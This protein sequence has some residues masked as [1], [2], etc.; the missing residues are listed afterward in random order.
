MSPLREV[1][2]IAWPTVL[3]MSSYTVMQFVDKLM[4]AQVGPLEVA[5]Q[6]NGG[7][8]SFVP[9]AFAMG[10]M[11]V[12]NTYVS[13]NL[14][15]GTP[16][17]GPKYAWAAMWISIAI[18]VLILL[19]F[20]AIM[21]WFF[22][23]LH[24]P[25]T[26]EQF[27]R[28]VALE[29]GYGRVLLLGGAII[30]VGRGMHHYFFGLH[31]PKV[32]AA[33]A[34]TGNIVNVFANYV[35]IFGAFGAPELG[36]FGAAIGTVIGT[37][38]EL[39][40]PAAI[41]LGP[42]MNR[43]LRS[44]GSWR[45]QWGP[46]RDLLKIGW[47]AAVQFGN[48]I[49]CWSIFMVVLVGRF[50]E[51]HMTAGWAT[52]GYMHLSFMPAVGFSVA[53]SSLVGKYIGAG[54]PDVAAARARTGL[55]IS[56]IY[57][58]VCAI[59]FFAF[60]YPLIDLF[61]AGQK[62]SPQQAKEIVEIGATLMICAALF[63]TA[64]AFGIVYSGALRGAGDTVWP[65]VVTIVFS[66]LFIVAGGWAMILL[67]PGLESIGPWIA[68]AAYVI[69]LGMFMWW[70]FEKGAWRKIDLLKRAEERPEGRVAPVSPGP[71]PSSPDAAVRDFAESESEAIL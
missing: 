53:V 58:T 66:W 2:H 36:L 6:G 64:D 63:Q 27:D 38:V 30:V 26:V 40:I 54:Q 65:G 52:L 14:G 32:I 19:P 68:A 24:D 59:I 31:R 34:I 28:L 45:P 44:R 20:A 71:P 57:M 50:G 9:I 62:V 8:W 51:N 10:L 70:R 5:A 3:T 39:I 60:R 67:W 55:R 33:A 56:M 11:T 7:I 41:F 47:P 18:W 1:W 17:Q 49:A 42:K 13:Q 61:V 15:A 69:V 37:A 22:A 46:I 21:P 23:H 29:S 43:E 4:L 35:L 16:E 48:E 12:V 25:S